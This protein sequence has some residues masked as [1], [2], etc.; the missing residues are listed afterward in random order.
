VGGSL[1]HGEAHCIGSRW[2]VPTRVDLR[3][4]ENGMLSRSYLLGRLQRSEEHCMSCQLCPV[5]LCVGV[6]R[7][8]A[9]TN[10]ES[11]ERRSQAGGKGPRRL[12]AEETSWRPPRARA[13]CRD[14]DTNGKSNDR[15]TRSPRTSDDDGPARAHAGNSFRTIGPPTHS[16][17]QTQ[18]SPAPAPSSRE[19]E[20]RRS[21]RRER[22]FLLW[23]ARLP[24]ASRGVEPHSLTRWYDRDGQRER[25]CN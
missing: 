7:R 19:R 3:W 14:C 16:R 9:V 17:A 18:A 15:S 8:D 23:R 1:R 4:H 6:G 25:T 24:R 2:R 20:L 21:R 22:F 11:R 13:G 5:S 12:D 10:V